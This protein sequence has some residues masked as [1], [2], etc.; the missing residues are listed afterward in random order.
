MNRRVQAASGRK[1]LRW[2]MI[3]P[4]VSIPELATTISGR[5]WERIPFE[6]STSLV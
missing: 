3:R 5:G 2:C 4:P 1:S 6:A